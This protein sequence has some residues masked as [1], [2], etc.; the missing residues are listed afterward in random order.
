MLL[1]ALQGS[2]GRV[3]RCRMRSGIGQDN[4]FSRTTNATALTSGDR[5]AAGRRDPH[6]AR[7]SF[8]PIF[9][10]LPNQV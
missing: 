8:P 10:R 5:G 2:T 6:Y 1:R 4:W 3:P 9:Q 7:V